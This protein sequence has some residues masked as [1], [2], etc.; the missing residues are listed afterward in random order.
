MN[1]AI[2]CNCKLAGKLATL[3]RSTIPVEGIDFTNLIMVDLKAGER[4]GRHTHKFH[5]ALYYPADTEPILVEPVAG[6]IIYLPPGT[7]H[8]VPTVN[9]SRASM[10]MLV[11]Q[12]TT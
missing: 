1:H 7:P 10:A 8:S 3:M 4:I 5:T 9:E 11:K 12:E 6:M 2:T